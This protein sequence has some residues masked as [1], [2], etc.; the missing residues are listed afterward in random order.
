[1]LIVSLQLTCCNWNAVEQ[2]TSLITEQY[3]TTVSQYQCLV[4]T[5]AIHWLVIAQRLVN[6]SSAKLI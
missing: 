3:L 5:P 2:L 4:V 6:T 1:M